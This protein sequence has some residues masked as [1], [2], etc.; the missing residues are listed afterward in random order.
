MRLNMLWGRR[1][2]V[3]DGRCW[4]RHPPFFPAWSS[5]FSK[6]QGPQAPQGDTWQSMGQGTWQSCE[7]LGTG[8]WHS[9]FST[10]RDA[11][12]QSR[13]RGA[14]SGADETTKTCSAFIL[15]RFRSVKTE[16]VAGVAAVG[17]GEEGTAYLLLFLAVGTPVE[18]R[19]ARRW[20]RQENKKSPKKTPRSTKEGCEVDTLS[21]CLVR[22]LPVS[23]SEWW[24]SNDYLASPH[25][26]S[27]GTWNAGKLCPVTVGADT[28]EQA[29]L[30]GVRRQRQTTAT[31][32]R[33]VFY[34]RRW[35]ILRPSFSGYDR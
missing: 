27:L 26:A 16:G 20:R 14:K 34:S 3:S 25:R 5:Q 17:W 35:P 29:A 6:V 21:L 2:S 15:F 32:S 24:I 10:G 30:W 19:A 23:A 9:R 13:R 4:G 28:K 31:T 18:T 1:V 8:P 12:E 33:W 22:C 11:S 7:V